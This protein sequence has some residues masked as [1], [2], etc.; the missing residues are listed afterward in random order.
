MS[1]LQ[2]EAFV[3]TLV[4]EAGA[5]ALLAPRLG[6]VAWRAA[7]AGVVGSAISHPIFWPAAVALSSE[8]GGFTVPFLEAIVILFESIAYRLIARTKWRLSLLLS[9]V[10]N[11]TS[12]LV[13]WIVFALQ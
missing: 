2:L 12:W 11:L 10:A 6:V 8:L 4:I 1:T 7:L 13:G 9:L 5:A 3:M